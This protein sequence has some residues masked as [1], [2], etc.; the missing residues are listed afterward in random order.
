MLADVPTRCPE[1]V[2]AITAAVKNDR[3]T[4]LAAALAGLLATG[5]LDDARLYLDPRP[6]HYSRNLIWRDPANRFVV[7]GMSWGAGQGSPLHDHD[8]LWGGEIVVSGTM[9]ETRFRLLEREET[10]RY[11][12]S[13]DQG[14]LSSRGSVGMLVPPLEYHNFRNAGDSVARTV[15]V[16]GGDLAQAQMFT[17]ETGEWYRA[18][19]ITLTYDA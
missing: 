13:A 3:A 9:S 19:Q 8:G 16:Y 12:F 15:H 10:S 2:E 1:I 7:V 14:R 17:H 4:S 5:A 11:R 6:G 18:K